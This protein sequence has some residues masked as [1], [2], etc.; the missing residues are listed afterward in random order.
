MDPG[1]VGRV[2]E[3][4][5]LAGAYA[6]EG[7]SF[8]PVYGRRRVGKSELILRFMQECPG[9]YYLGKRAPGPMQL[10][11]FMQEAAV[12]LG[13]PLLAQLAPEGWKQ[14]LE[15]VV[16]RWKG[17]AKLVLA[18]DEFQWTAEASPE[19]PSVLQELWDRRWRRSGNIVLILCGSYVGF[20]E[21]EILG[22]RSPLFGRRTAQ[23]LLRPFSYREAA[24][25]HPAFGREAQAKTFFLCGGVPL[26]LRQFAS[27]RSVDQNIVHA[28]LH[29][30]AP[31]FREPEFLLREELR[32][33]ENYH[34]I[35]V[36]IASGHTSNKDIAAAAR[37]GNRALFYYLQQ[38]IELGYVVRRFPLGPARPAARHV[39]YVL[40]DPLLRF[41][42]RFV[43]PN[44]SYIAQMG[45][46]RAFLDRIRPHLAAYFGYCFERLCRDALGEIYRDEGVTA[47]FEIGEYWDSKAQVDVVGRR[48]DG[49]IDLGECKWGAVRSPRSVAAEFEETVSSY[50]APAGATLV[51]RVFTRLPVAPFAGDPAR[52]LRW[53]SLGDLYGPSHPSTS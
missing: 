38:L 1:F 40:E 8:I 21:R 51:R 52:P 29:E 9:V 4:K 34:A 20:M 31:L 43:F 24:A 42:F 28:L 35:L 45:P 23:I 13:E 26:Y 36:A 33:V 37:I 10:Q 3:L 48:D 53:H 47:A 30:H 25:F 15:A 12:A 19:L 41:W 17:A 11:E 14:A 39:R 2:T 5:L 18:F 16:S 22:R 46:E 49:T 27:D 6:G 32:D 7:S 50:P 44:T